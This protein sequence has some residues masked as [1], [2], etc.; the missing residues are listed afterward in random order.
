MRRR[1][2]A[3]IFSADEIAAIG[4]FCA[5]MR[6]DWGGLDILRD[7]ADGRIYVVDVNKTDVGPVIALSLPEKLRSVAL[8]ASALRA[9]VEAG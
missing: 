2:P 5:A 1:R 3:E 7:R 6:L 9:L 8:L 4:R